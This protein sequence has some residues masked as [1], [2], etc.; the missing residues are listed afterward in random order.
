MFWLKKTLAVDLNNRKTIY[1]QLSVLNEEMGNAKEALAWEQKYS[2]LNDSLN[3]ENVKL[4]INK[5]ESKFN[6]AEKEKK[7]STP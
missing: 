2:T 3:T 7:N 6:A 4:E 1:K 5:I